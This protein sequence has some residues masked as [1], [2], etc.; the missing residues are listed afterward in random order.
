MDQL[1]KDTHV[2]GESLKNIRALRKSNALDFS[3]A[4]A[5]SQRILHQ[6]PTMDMHF[7]FRMERNGLSSLCC[8][9]GPRGYSPPP[10]CIRQDTN[11]VKSFSELQYQWCPLS[12]GVTTRT[13]RWFHLT[14]T[15]DPD[16]DA[17]YAYL[18]ESYDLYFPD[19]RECLSKWGPSSTRTQNMVERSGFNSVDSFLEYQSSVKIIKIFPIEFVDRTNP[20]INAF[21]GNADPAFVITDHKS[22]S[23][24]AKSFTGSLPLDT[25][26]RT[27]THFLFLMISLVELLSRLKRL[28]V[29]DD[30]SALL[31]LIPHRRLFYYLE[32][33]SYV[34]NEDV[35]TFSLSHV[36]SALMTK[37]KQVGRLPRDLP[38]FIVDFGIFDDTALSSVDNNCS[39]STLRLD[40]E[41]D[42]RLQIS[43]QGAGDSFHI[44]HPSLLP[45]FISTGGL[46][47]LIKDLLILPHHR[48]QVPPGSRKEHALTVDEVPANCMKRA[49]LH[50]DDTIMS[51][52]A[53]KRIE[54]TFP[55][56]E[57]TFW[58][59]RHLFG[60]FIKSATIS[61]PP[62]GT[63]VHDFV[64]TNP[65]K[66]I[67]MFSSGSRSHA[68]AVDG[69]RG[70]IIDPVE[71]CGEVERSAAGLKKLRINSFIQV[72]VLRPV[73][74]SEK[75]R[76]ALNKKTGLPW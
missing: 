25:T 14:C 19:V 69:T 16:A 37:V 52:R 70:K 43:F 46:A 10:L 56:H 45:A 11:D 40:P 22:L 72:Y 29:L 66:M 36:F 39:P 6:H 48:V 74:V 59:L 63:D 61:R 3:H 60:D 54:L 44:L 12:N 38:D 49:L 13:T 30:E 41:N 64:M 65:S 24:S 71:E 51:P 5:A 27:S 8:I 73:E 18:Q 62:K 31:A 57:L 58:Q 23:P 55:E 32:S 35:N 2:V 15:A 9:V 1:W 53:K 28:D 34:I 33:Q 76:R 4:Y 68:V 50:L 75:R 26:G 47:N 21:Y 17:D 42:S 67:A 20:E 7:F